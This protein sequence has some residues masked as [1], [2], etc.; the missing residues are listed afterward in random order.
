MDKKYIIKALK[1]IGERKTLTLDEIMKEL[2]CSCTDGIAVM[3]RLLE[4]GLLTPSAERGVFETKCDKKALDKIRIEEGL[5]KVRYNSQKI[6]LFGEK[7][8]KEQMDLLE[9]FLLNDKKAL[10]EVHPDYNDAVYSLTK[11]GLVMIN[12]EVIYPRIERE[13][14]KEISMAFELAQSEKEILEE[15][16]KKKDALSASEIYDLLDETERESETP[17]ETVEPQEESESDGPDFD[18]ITKRASSLVGAKREKEEK[19]EDTTVYFVF[20][21]LTGAPVRGTIPVTAKLKDLICKVSSAITEDEREGMFGGESTIVNIMKS[22]SD[23]CKTLANVIVD[24]PV[25][26]CDVP[27]KGTFAK[28]IPAQV[29][30]AVA[31]GEPL[32]FFFCP[33]K[34]I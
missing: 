27:W 1:I 19:K 10:S 2:N 12:D 20:Q 23:D 14:I 11:L 33:P 24:S 34:K 22:N 32:T 4:K 8:T 7:L 17:I 26:R 31:N 25:G 29:E 21:G 16:K 3:K 30:Y 15:E 6:V 28:N 9:C 13:Q 18:F 5:V